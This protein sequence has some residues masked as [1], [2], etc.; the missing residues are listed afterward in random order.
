MAHARATRSPP[1]LLDHLLSGDDTLMIAALSLQQCGKLLG[2]PLIDAN[3]LLELPDA[4][5]LGRIMTII[6][7]AGTQDQ[8][9]RHAAVFRGFGPQPHDAG[10]A[11]DDLLHGAHHRRIGWKLG[12]RRFRPHLYFE[13]VSGRRAADLLDDRLWV[14]R[15]RVAELDA[16]GGEPDSPVGKSAGIVGDEV[17]V[18]KRRII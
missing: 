10:L 16:A 7:M 5:P 15:L 8:R 9:R 12:R 2:N 14:D 1:W 13:P 4:D 11:A 6:D 17:E 18:A 3:S